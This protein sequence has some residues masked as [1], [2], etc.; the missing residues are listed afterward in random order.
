MIPSSEYGHIQV[1]YFLTI[2]VAKHI[3]TAECNDKGKEISKIEVNI[4]TLRLIKLLA[5]T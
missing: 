1:E 3:V 2:E 5:E 4:P